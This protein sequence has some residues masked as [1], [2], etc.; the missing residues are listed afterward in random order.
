MKAGR[1]RECRNRSGDRK[2]DAICRCR[3]HA[4]PSLSITD[5][6][7]GTPTPWRGNAGL[8]ES[9]NAKETVSLEKS[10]AGSV[11]ATIDKNNDG[12]EGQTIAFCLK[13]VEL[14][15]DHC[16]DNDSTCCDPYRSCPTATAEQKEIA[17]AQ[18]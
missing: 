13:A 5:A 6:P 10:S 4:L 11:T 18:V 15:R 17:F 8:T 2:S 3:A 1:S 7:Y 9:R 12:P 14:Y 16:R